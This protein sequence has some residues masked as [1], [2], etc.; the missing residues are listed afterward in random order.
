MPPPLEQVRQAA[1][2]RPQRRG[3]FDRAKRQVGVSALVG[4]LPEHRQC[5]DE[6]GIELDR[7][8]ER[9]QGRASLTERVRG[10]RGAKMQDWIAGTL[11]QFL[12]EER[13][14]LVGV[15]PFQGIPG[16]RR[17]HVQW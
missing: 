17:D 6:L 2:A 3:S 15:T 9:R 10:R 4:D 14:R 11:F 8:L 16:L 5:L 12:T 7:L 13:C 1:V